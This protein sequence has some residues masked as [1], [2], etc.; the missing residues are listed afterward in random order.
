MKRKIVIEDSFIAPAVN[1]IVQVKRALLFPAA[2]PT[3][4][5]VLRTFFLRFMFCRIH[6]ALKFCSFV[7]CSHKS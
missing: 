1:I 2:G 6:L 3:A 4:S 5:D 7:V